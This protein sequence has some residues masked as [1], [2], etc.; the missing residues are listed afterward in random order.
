MLPYHDAVQ[1]VGVEIRSLVNDD[2]FQ[3]LLISSRKAKRGRT[4]TDHER[5]RHKKHC[6]GKVRLTQNQ[7]AEIIRLN[8][9]ND[10]AIKKS[11]SELATMFG[12]SKS[13]ISKI[14][15]Q[16]SN[17]KGHNRQHRSVANSPDSDPDDSLEDGK[18]DPWHPCFEETENFSSIA[19]LKVACQQE[20]DEIVLRKVFIFLQRRNRNSVPLGCFSEL[21]SILRKAHGHD[22]SKRFL[23][24]YLDDDGDDILVTSDHELWVAIKKHHPHE[25]FKLR[26]DLVRENHP[27]I[28]SSTY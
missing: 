14:L 26:L 3:H 28:L 16:A 21:T 23:L 9:S 20:S 25:T 17:P 18:F 19:K 12:K 11:Q 5:I 7:R 8:Q 22:I 6:Q 27:C 24:S 4:W 13:A 15:K 10:P 1:Q 2:Q